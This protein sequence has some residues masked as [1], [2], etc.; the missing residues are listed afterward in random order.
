VIV[1]HQ[2]T[3]LRVREEVN[4][5]EIQEIGEA[6]LAQVNSDA[7]SNAPLVPVTA[8]QMNSDAQIN[9]PSNAPLVPVTADQMNSDAQIN[10]PSNAPL[11]LVMVDRL[12]LPKGDSGVLRKTTTDHLVPGREDPGILLGAT[13]KTGDAFLAMMQ[14][15]EIAATSSVV[16]NQVLR[17]PLS[18]TLFAQRRDLHRLEPVDVCPRNMI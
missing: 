15:M 17:C 8:G 4:S 5:L 11:V 12:V 16:W 2:I 6:R 9:A 7:P 10:A 13:T 3:L 1:V 14:D 18:L